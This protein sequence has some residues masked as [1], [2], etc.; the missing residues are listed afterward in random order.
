MGVVEVLSGFL[1]TVTGLIVTARNAG[2]RAETV[3]LAIM[4]AG[5]SMNVVC[6][7]L[8]FATLGGLIVAIGAWREKAA[9]GSV[10]SAPTASGEKLAA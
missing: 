2:D 10:S 4:G 5:E 7:S 1:G 9:V 6:L 8:M 3:K